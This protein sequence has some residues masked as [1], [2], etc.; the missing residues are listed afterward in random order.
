MSRV[1]EKPE[2]IGRRVEYVDFFVIRDSF[3]YRDRLVIDSSIEE[4]ETER[5]A[6]IFEVLDYFD[7]LER[8]LES[9][10][11]YFVKNFKRK[12][13]GLWKM[14]GDVYKAV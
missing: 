7:L 14:S 1:F 4:G 9:N 10:G 6:G 11:Y 5:L 8:Y 13:W 3:W 2:D 12:E